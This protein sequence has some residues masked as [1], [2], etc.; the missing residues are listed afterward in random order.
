M[1]ATNEDRAKFIFIIILSRKLESPYIGFQVRSAGYK[2]L[3]AHTCKYTIRYVRSSPINM[4]R[5]WNVFARFSI[6]VATAVRAVFKIY[7][8]LYK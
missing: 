3:H 5:R 4:S 2:C 8:D 1:P 6:L 7:D